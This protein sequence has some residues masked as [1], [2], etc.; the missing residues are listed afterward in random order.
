MNLDRNNNTPRGIAYDED[1]EVFC[2]II[3][4]PQNSERLLLCRASRPL[5]VKAL[6]HHT[7][8]TGLGQ[9]R[10]RLG[11]WDSVWSFLHEV[12]QNDNDCNRGQTRQ[13]GLKVRIIVC[14]HI[15]DDSTQLHLSS[16]TAGLDKMI[17]FF[18]AVLKLINR[19]FAVDR[20]DNSCPPWAP[21]CR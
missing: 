1:G 17:L 12:A 13:T 19:A 16:S 7:G 10:P 21:I 2:E 8:P 4:R 14:Y 9:F 6:F 5:K 18:N 11:D 3:L 20:P 15:L